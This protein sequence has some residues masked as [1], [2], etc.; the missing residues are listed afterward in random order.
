MLG[1]LSGRLGLAKS[2]HIYTKYGGKSYQ[3][4]AA[5]WLKE[6][7]VLCESDTPDLFWAV[8]FIYLGRSYIFSVC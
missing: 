5:H 6:S 4:K 7:L 2:F 8:S 1:G 3:S